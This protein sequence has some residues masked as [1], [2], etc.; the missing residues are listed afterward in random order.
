MGTSR[1][2]FVAF[3]Y[4]IVICG[5]AAIYGLRRNHSTTIYAMWYAFSFSFILASALEFLPDRFQD[6]GSGSGLGSWVSSTIKLMIDPRGEFEFVGAVLLIG[7]GPQ[8]LTYFLSG[9][10]GSASAPRFVWQLEQFAI[11]SVIKFFAVLSGFANGQ[12]W[13]D[14]WARGQ[15]SPDFIQNKYTIDVLGLNT[16]PLSLAFIL[17]WARLALSEINWTRPIFQP[18]RLA[19]AKV[20]QFATR[21]TVASDEGLKP[22]AGE[23]DLSSKPAP[24]TNSSQ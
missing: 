17:A 22:L 9:W 15:I 16:I 1:Y 13:G 7:I 21:H 11:W 18:F 4:L 24:L 3:V 6:A 12:M 23:I 2:L 5:A 10:S 14:G 20:H 19:S 8:I